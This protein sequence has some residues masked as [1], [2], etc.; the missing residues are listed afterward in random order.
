L[1]SR[2]SEG[3]NYNQE[4]K[5]RVEVGTKLKRE[6]HCAANIALAFSYKLS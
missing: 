4:R 2:R 1:G 6:V 3:S 5:H